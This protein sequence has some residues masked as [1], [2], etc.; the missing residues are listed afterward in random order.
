MNKNIYCK[1]GTSSE[2]GGREMVSLWDILS[3]IKQ[4][5]RWLIGGLLV[6]CLCSMGFLFVVPSLYE[7]K[8]LLQTAKVLGDDLEPAPQMLE[9]LKFPT[10][11]GKEQLAACD[12]ISDD[13]ALTLSKRISPMVLKGTSLILVSY[14]ASSAD[15]AGRCLTAVMDRVIENQSRISGPVIESA[16]RQLELA[17]NQLADAERLQN[18]LDQRSVSSLDVVDNKFSQPMVLLSAT[19]SKRDEVAQLRKSV[20]EQIAN[21]EP[22]NTQPAQLVEPIY[23]PNEAAFPKT[24]LSI[25]IGMFAGLV[26]GGLAFFVRQSW[27]ERKAA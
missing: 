16:K 5:W 15:L 22:P 1:A 14:R 13:P 17:K 27:L 3:F 23:V 4:G 19:L 24:L 2:E 9:H 18:Q 25:S 20:I 11:Y 7:A 8:A 21:L 12:V 26:L 6:G 10:F